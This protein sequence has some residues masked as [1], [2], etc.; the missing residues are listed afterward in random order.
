M[1]RALLSIAILLLSAAPPAA[2]A[3]PQFKMPPPDLAQVLPLVSPAL[4]KPALPGSLAAYPPSPQPV[5]PLPRARV[6]TDLAVQ[7][8]A[9]APPPRFL[10]CN[11]LGTVLGVV[12]E[13]VEC[14]RARFQRGEYEDAREALDGAVKRASDAALL[15]E[16]RYWLGE[17]LI[18]LG[19]PDQAA[20]AML[21]VVHA[22]PR[23]D[24]GFHAALKYG[25]LSLMAGDPARALATL[26]ALVK[27]GPSPALVPWAQHGRAVALYGLGRY[28]E[29][30]E[31]WT[32][33]LGQTLPVPVAGEAPFWLGDTL[34]RLGEYKDAVARLKTFTG[35]GPRLLIDTGLLRL[36]WWSRAAGEPLA[37]VQTYRGAMS[38]YPKLPEI[39]WAR[40]G[41][42]LALLDL[43]DYAAALDEARTLDA[44]DKTGA[45]G[46]PVLLAV[47]RWATEK[48][49]ADDARALEQELLG[50]TLEPATRAYVLL[51]AGEVERDAGQMSEAHGRFELVLAR[52]GAPA[53]GW[54]AGLRL[55]QMDLESREIAQARTR[56]DALLNEPLS[57]ELRG[58]ALALA[59]EAAYAGRA[60][61]EAAA[62]YSRFLA[63]FPTSPQAPSVMLA[64]GWA[65]FRR[66]RFEAA[67]DTWTRF[68]TI[69]RA[70]P[71]APAALLLAA[72]L[73]A[74][75][76]DTVG[77]RALLDGLVT[78]YPEGE[79]A[80]IARLNRSIL[81]IRAG[82]ASSALGDLTELIR[83]APLSPYTGRMRLARGV[84]LVTDG[85][86]AEAARE[87][88]SA[89]GQG[90]GASANL[91]L[92]RVAFDRG[93]WDEAEREFVEARDTGAGAVAASAEYGIAAVLWNQ[94][95]TDEFKRFAQAL[96]ARPP[97][98]ANT[99]N[100]L[101]AAAALAAEEGRW[102]DARTLAMR[103]VGEF[104]TTDA[105]PAA[106]SLVGTAAGRGG[107]WPLA[108][109]TFQLLTERY[110]GYKTGREARLDYAEA[111][112]RTGAL[113]EASAKLQEIIDAS[114]RDPELPR[115]LILLGRTHEAR[116][117]GASAL[118]VYKRV[119]RE[120]PAFE[121][122]ALL[123]NARVLLL[124]GNWDEAR[125]LLER[126]VAA[127]DA[128]VAVEAAYRLGE[129][130]R[131]AGRH[132]QAVD[133]YMTAAYV[134]P[135]TPLA[136]RAL[137]GAGQS[138]TA[139]K[140]PD[141][142]IIVY[143]KLLAGKS[144]E[145]DVADAA[146]KGLRALGVN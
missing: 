142:A 143:K 57:A 73:A 110:P 36:A 18:R 19:R 47:D 44:A 109:E 116:G 10:A 23:S 31:V 94:G 89:Q 75:S 129:G 122:A 68:A 29:A 16:A 26:D 9:A 52:P 80:D 123:G 88:K 118:D 54:F 98:P 66:G 113:A 139:L 90:E 92:G 30:R 50:R 91:G 1:T 105:A 107:E 131:G 114:P 56:I 97:D 120:Y 74:R 100:V 125:P 61:D 93:Q 62:R 21:L 144:V 117:D 2:A 43:D 15:R 24:V 53:L 49:R 138:F 63:E 112:Y 77:A 8:V 145:P 86:G 76:G 104:P 103:T 111:L 17:T 25:W 6:E 46:L 136:R 71:R 102:K 128:A 5:P 121:G 67:R 96:L 22:D 20:Q 11:P 38:A 95:K 70:D 78:R 146:K 35:G 14:G 48:R 27:V 127:G 140:Q 41:L 42:V 51:L 34:G 79:Y 58:A 40:A 37:A 106:L 28:A 130:L 7:P 124:A 137:L 60:W 32:R 55:A 81:A 115:A 83:R 4:D 84:V 59:G 64:L 12:S 39:L 65:E 99:P 33:L 87:F 141:S 45:L 132:Q 108:S 133:S 69:N 126:A 85:K 3:E 82:R 13:L 135:D 101:A 119:G 134:A 72:E